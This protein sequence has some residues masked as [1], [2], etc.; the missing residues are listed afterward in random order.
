MAPS[1]LESTTHSAPANPLESRRER[2]NPFLQTGSQ[3]QLDGA[4]RSSGV[5]IHTQEHNFC[6]SYRW[7][8]RC[9][10]LG[11]DSCR[12]RCSRTSPG[13][14]RLVRHSQAWL[15]GHPNP[16]PHRHHAHFRLDLLA[17]IGGDGGPTSC[18]S[19]RVAL[20][21]SWPHPALRFTCTVSGEP[22]DAIQERRNQCAFLPPGHVQ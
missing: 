11:R 2:E 7:S 21:G 3:G 15:E 13:S 9:T 19:R 17:C 20:L 18:T 4:A 10:D 5:R 6:A 1:S 16:L 22:R 14:G 8:S 12:D